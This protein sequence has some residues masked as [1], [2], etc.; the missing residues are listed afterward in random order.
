MSLARWKKI[1]DYAEI[2]DLQLSFYMPIA[3]LTTVSCILRTVGQIDTEV[4][5]RRVKR[6]RN[7]CCSSFG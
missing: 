4:R 6:E 2:V 7:K 5:K 1:S 3:Q